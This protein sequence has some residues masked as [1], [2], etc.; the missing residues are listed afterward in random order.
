MANKTDD[1]GE[2][3]IA[4]VLETGG[5][6]VEKELRDYWELMS[7]HSKVLDLIT[8]GK[9]SKTNYTYKAIEE[10]FR[11]THQDKIK[12]NVMAFLGTAYN[13]DKT[14]IELSDLFDFFEI[15]EED[16]IQDALVSNGEVKK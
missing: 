9:M 15:T 2:S 14:T 5:E 1:M 4:E 13:P 3:W 11:D 8:D 16:L 7:V 6:Q 12:E 10:V